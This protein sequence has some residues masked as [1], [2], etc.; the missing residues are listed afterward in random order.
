MFGYARSTGVGNN[1]TVKAP[2]FDFEESA[3]PDVGRWGFSAYNE[4]VPDHVLDIVDRG[5]TYNLLLGFVV[6]VE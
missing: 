6:R 1:F 2:P 4:S 5:V 3:D